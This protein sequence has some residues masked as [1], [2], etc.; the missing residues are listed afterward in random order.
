[1]SFRV[2]LWLA[3]MT[4]VAGVTCAALFVTHQKVEATYQK[5]LQEQFEAQVDYFYAQQDLR[6]EPLK[7][8]CV[9]AARSAK[10]IKAMEG[11]TEDEIYESVRAELGLVAPQLQHRARRS[12]KAAVDLSTNSVEETMYLRVL[13][14]NGTL[15][16][17]RDSPLPV[18]NI[19]H[20]LAKM[21]SFMGKL[22]LQQI[23][24]LAPPSRNFDLQEV[25]ATKITDPETGD[26]LGAILLGFPVQNYG[27]KTLNDVSQL[28]TGIW[29][30]DRIYS[31]T[32]PSTAQGR[33]A[34]EVKH[35]AEDMDE[36]RESFNLDFG[37]LSHRVF[38]KIL[39]PN[40]PF[41]AAY[42]VSLYSL[43][44]AQKTEREMRGRILL[45]GAGAICTGLFLSWFLS[46]GLST[47]LQEVVRATRE[48]QQ[49]NYQIRVPIRG[50]DELGQ[51]GAAFNQMAEDL[52]LKEKFRS[53]LNMVTDK[54]VA[55][56]LLHGNVTT[57]GETREVSILFC[58]IRG[59]TRLSEGIPPEKIIQILNQHFTPMA[60]IVTEHKGV[61]DKYVGDLV[62]A[63][64][65]APKSYGDDAC[66]AAAC[67]RAMIVERR[68]INKRSGMQLEIGI[69]LATGRVVVGCVGSADHLNYTV[70]GESVNLA[71][72]L[73]SQAAPGQIIMDAATRE[74]LG[75]QPNLVPLPPLLLK[76]FTTSVQAYLLQETPEQEIAQTEVL[77]S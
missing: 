16:H 72:R 6:L 45:F 43:A 64:F 48:I 13:E 31:S 52:A 73:C 15:I 60:R 2:K 50:R 44:G 74:R 39:N 76:G 22:E 5:L 66:N 65:G 14:V 1:M 49:G 4:L 47:P 62:M 53:V 23:G 12:K 25:I 55:E 46:R 36:V 69:G 38:F 29:Y 19:E 10:L 37:G 8:K 68:R 24:Y 11:G 67:A 51:L 32:I 71:S 42:Q 57:G 20:Q 26:T 75:K 40:S 61:V 9:Q 17:P 70:L 27:E 33:L 3:M 35:E 77:K 41:R 28:Q 63:I 21:A 59:F 18:P 58:D 54:E 34:R 7:E 30:N 56:E